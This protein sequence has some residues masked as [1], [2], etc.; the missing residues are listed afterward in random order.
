MSERIKRFTAFILALALA[1]GNG[2]AMTGVQ[3]QEKEKIYEEEEYRIVL[4]QQ[5]SWEEGYVAQAVITNTGTKSIGNWEIEL[6]L[7][8]GKIEDAW[9]VTVEETET[10]Y[11]LSCQSYNRKIEAGQTAIFGFCATGS[12]VEN[13]ASLKLNQKK[14]GAI[15]SEDYSVSYNIMGQWSDSTNV[16]VTI[17]NNTQQTIHN[18]ELELQVNAVVTSIWGATLLQQADGVCTI[19]G[20][21]GAVDIEEGQAV[22]FGMCLNLTDA[23]GFCPG[24]EQLSCTDGVLQKEPD[25][26]ADTTQEPASTT[27]DQGTTEGKEKESTTQ[28]TPSGDAVS[29]KET[30]HVDTDWDDTMIHADAAQEYSQG[31]QDRVKV[32][33]LDSG[34][35]YWKDI[36][37][38]ERA[39]FV[40]DYEDS[41]LLFDDLSGHGT[42]VAALLAADSSKW[43]TEEEGWENQEEEESDYSEEEEEYEGL[44]EE[45][46]DNVEYS[47][48]QT[49]TAET[50][51]PEL[52][53]GAV[54]AYEELKQ[55][56]EALTQQQAEEEQEEETIEAPEGE[57]VSSE[58]IVSSGEGSPESSG[59]TAEESAEATA[60]L[61]Q[62]AGMEA[63]A[64]LFNGEGKTLQGVNPNVDIYSARVLDANNEAAVSRVVKAIEWAI[65]K[66]VQVI[67]IGFGMEQDSDSLH[68]VIQKAYKKGILIVAPA[69]NGEQMEYPAAYEEVIAVGS[70]TCEGKRSE[71]SASGDALE[72]MAPGE[73]VCSRGAFGILEQYTGTS[74]A[75][76]QVVGLA[77][78]LWQRDLKQPAECIRQLMDVTAN[79][80]GEKTL[81]GY[82]LIDCRAAM[83]KYDDFVAWYA[84]QN[85]SEETEK[86]SS[87]DALSQAQQELGENQ[88]PVLVVEEEVVRGCWSGTG[89]EKISNYRGITFLKN[90][91]IWSDKKDSKVAGMTSNPAFHGYYQKYGK[92][93]EKTKC[94]YI[95]GYLC[96]VQAAEYFKNEGTLEG[97]T[98]QL[99][100]GVDEIGGM[101][102]NLQKKWMTKKIIEQSGMKKEN[103][104][105]TQAEKM[106]GAYFIYGMALHTLSDI[107]AHSSFCY[108]SYTY[109]DENGIR[110]TQNYGWSSVRH[111]SCVI[112]GK[113]YYLSNQCDN[114]Q[115]KTQRYKQAEIVVSTALNS[116]QNSTFNNSVSG[117][118]LVFSGMTEKVS[119]ASADANVQYDASGNAISGDIR[120]DYIKKQFAIKNFCSCLKQSNNVAQTA[121]TLQTI[122]KQYGTN[123][124]PEEVIQQKW[125]MFDNSYVKNRVSTWK[126][127]GFKVNSLKFSSKIKKFK[128][129]DVTQSKKN[130]AENKKNKKNKKYKK[131]SEIVTVSLKKNT[132]PL[133]KGHTYLIVLKG[134]KV[135]KTMFKKTKT[136]SIS[137]QSVT[138]SGTRPKEEPYAAVKL[139]TVGEEEEKTTLDSEECM[140]FGGQV[141]VTLEDSDMAQASVDGGVVEMDKDPDHVG[142]AL[143]NRNVYLYE[144]DADFIE[145][146]IYYIE[147]EEKPVPLYHTTTDENGYYCFEGVAPGKYILYMEDE[148][149]MMHKWDFAV[150]IGAT[151][152][153]NELARLVKHEYRGKSEA[154]GIIRDAVSQKGVEGL[155]VTVQASGRVLRAKTDEQGCYV[156]KNIFAGCYQAE[157][158]DPERKYA[159]SE[160]TVVI[161]GRK[162]YNEQQDALVSKKMTEDEIRVVATWGPENKNYEGH[163]AIKDETDPVFF[164]DLYHNY[165]REN[166]EIFEK[167]GELVADVFGNWSSGVSPEIFTVYDTSENFDYHLYN[168]EFEEE[169]GEQEMKREMV[170]VEVYQGA[171]DKAVQTFYAPYQEG[172]WWRVFH[173]DAN[174]NTFWQ[175]TKVTT[176]PSFHENT[177]KGEEP[178]KNGWERNPVTNCNI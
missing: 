74:M 2:I 78:L 166:Q 153:H 165:V 7:E 154:R 21:G 103:G 3:A 138:A 108:N 50:V 23:Q 132:M 128:I 120:K 12:G 164:V 170:K 172:L 152:V 127:L 55:M 28:S 96:L 38:V 119:L 91:A 33:V 57:P 93:G 61:P 82:G 10:G 174:T 9:N 80:L 81:Y 36:N 60:G 167:N 98:Y 26:S 24:G 13:V 15:C 134:T 150:K 45:E 79:S 5:S 46:L 77:T 4:T 40:T 69:G 68:R 20:T 49:M 109:K 19:D 147:E 51:K 126:K 88:A 112:N 63:F 83:E 14:K 104:V 110:M 64:N 72:L 67:Q 141:D 42:A 111:G 54:T 148:D 17:H 158:R 97:F 157:V 92:K 122:G 34:V 124:S 162:E 1:V 44:E 95:E 71:Q 115:Y 52:E 144:W 159:K 114:V 8:N 131:K 102:E 156:V 121:E 99:A 53:E 177:M 22:T 18:W 37:V 29:Q 140:L 31:I 66:E 32:A 56:L 142:Q 70:V 27:A 106:K 89:H 6:E 137:G 84:E 116:L 163:V 160:F 39:N 41:S 178:W 139:F 143:S 125:Q 25:G 105:Y 149:Y 76:P 35:D 135:T 94:N 129:I 87:A 16:E 123:L 130:I 75:V 171:G 101:V 117:S 173:Y 73:L 48:V 100:E 65:E 133:T 161:D 11:K 59:E 85:H 43:N 151:E 86:S 155:E 58:E 113:K 136:A 30:E 146:Q 169:T 176:Y 118:I 168:F 145:H 62:P 175:N 47:I 90:G 107:F